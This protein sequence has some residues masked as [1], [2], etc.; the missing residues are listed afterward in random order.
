[1]ATGVAASRPGL[2]LA[3][4][5]FALLVMVWAAIRPERLL[6]LAL[7]A[8]LFGPTVVQVTGVAFVQ[9]ADE[10]LLLAFLMTAVG[11]RLASGQRLTRFP[12]GKWFVLFALTGLISSEIAAIPWTTS[13]AGA[14]LLCKGVL[15]GWGAAQLD[16]ESRAEGVRRFAVA[17]ALLLVVTGALNLAVPAMWTQTFSGGGYDGTA[18]AG[19][20]AVIGWFK[21]PSFYAQVAGLTAVAL[22]AFRR[23][24]GRG[25]RAL[26]ATLVVLSFLSLR[27]KSWVSVPAALLGALAIRSKGAAFAL[28]VA[29][30]FAAWVV[31][32]AQIQA[33]VDRTVTGL[34]QADA[35]RVILYSGAFD[36]AEERLPLGA[37][38]GRWGSAPSVGEDYSPEYLRR[39]LYLA[40]GFEVSG[41]RD[42]TYATDTFWPI[43]IGET[44]W[45]G[46]AFYLLGVLAMVR[47]FRRE[48]GAKDPWRRTLGVTGV[49]WSILLL[50]ESAAAPVFTGPPTFPWLFVL[51]GASVALREAA[52]AQPPTAAEASGRRVDGRVIGNGFP[53]RP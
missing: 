26:A 41:R 50:I 34:S 18:R 8:V 38:F 6:M 19:F 20:P 9:N 43:V 11:G 36:I 51:A 22:F 12:G 42:F 5:P 17:V 24:L 33:V 35:P 46:L 49:G 16:W 15:L 31:G 44:G 40:D 45:L 2:L 53:R 30:V 37:G 21:H 14:L 28:A 39:G 10:A 27:R 3:L 47:L 23:E 4:V 29:G 48:V 32:G 7:A 1:L 13:G 25:G 52:D